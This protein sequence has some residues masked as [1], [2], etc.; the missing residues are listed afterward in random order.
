MEKNTKELIWK[1]VN[2]FFGIE[3][4]CSTPLGV[5]S[6]RE[7]DITDEIPD[8]GIICELYLE[9]IA[10]GDFENAETAKK[11]AEDYL[12]NIFNKLGSFLGGVNGGK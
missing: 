2:T 4:R 12:I 8:G 3:H 5:F 10:I 6:F 11:Y 7:I 1:K 9:H